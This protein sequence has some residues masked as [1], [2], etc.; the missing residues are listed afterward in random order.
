MEQD[1]THALW[2]GTQDGL[3]KFNGKDFE[4]FVAGET[5]GLESS[6][7]LSSAAAKNG[8]LWFGTTNGLSV[9]N[10]FKEK[11]ETFTISTGIPMHV[12]DIFIADDQKIWIASSTH[13]IQ[14]FNPKVKKFTGIKKRNELQRSN[15]IC[16]LANDHVLVGTQDN[17]MFRW[18]PK[19]NGI[20]NLVKSEDRG[21]IEVNNIKK[22]GK[23]RVFVCTNK[24]LFRYLAPSG[25]LIQPFEILQ[26]NYGVLNVTDVISE[27][28]TWYISTANRG[29]FTIR[30]DGSVFNSSQDVFQKYALLFNEINIIYRDIFGTFWLGTQRGISNFDPKNQGFYGVGPVAD[31]TQGLPNASVWSFAEDPT[32]QFLYVGTD[33]AV[34]QYDRSGGKFRHFYRD[35][36]ALN[37]TQRKET[38]VLSIFVISNDRLLVAC[39]DGLYELSILKNSYSFKPLIAHWVQDPL[40]NKAYSICYYKEQKFFIGTRGGVI[41]YDLQKNTT[42]IFKHNANDRRNSIVAGACRL[43]YKDKNGKIWFATSGGGLNYL[44]E[45]EGELLIVPYER[46]DILAKFSK[47]Y[48]TSILH[49]SSDEYWLG[50]VGSGVLKHNVET[51]KTT[52]YDKTDGLPNNFIY[53]LLMDREGQ[54]WMSTNRGLCRFSP[55]SGAVRNYSEVDGLMSNEMNL[56]AYM[57]ALD[58]KLYFGGISGF[59]YFDPRTLSYNRPEVEVVFTKFKLDDQWLKPGE[60]HGLFGSTFA[61]VDKITLNHHQR[62]FT[63][64][65]QSSDLSNPELISYRY[66]LIGS[67]E[68]MINLGNSNELRFN[69]LPYGEYTLRVYGKKGVGE[70]SANPAIL[71]I[72]LIPPFWFRW[73]FFVLL[74]VFLALAIVYYIRHKLDAER[75]EQVR[76]EM[77]IQE[78]TREIR[79]QSKK[80]ERQR[81]QIEEERNKVIEQQ[82]LLQAEKEKSD[83]LLNNI[84]PI[85]TAEELKRKGR[86]NARAYRKV[87]VLFTDFVGFTKI[88]DVLRPSELVQRLDF[89]FT[90]F[91]E[92][93]EQNNLEK[94]K[95]IGDAYMAAGGVPVRNNTNPVEACLAGLQIQKFIEQVRIES[96]AKGEPSWNLRLGINTGEVTAGVIGSK[97]FAYDVWGATVNQAQRMEMMGEPGKVTITGST[98]KHVMPFFETT[99]KGKVKSKSRGM[100]E[101]FTVDRIKPELSADGLG[102][103]PNDSFRK[104]FDLQMY[105]AIN[106]YKAERH[107]IKVLEKGLNDH[108]YYHCIDHT[109]D[110]V[111]AAESLA[112]QEGVTD[113]GLYLLKS[114]ATYHDAGFV[115]KY[116]DNEPI[117]ARMAEEILPNY[118]YT[119]DQIEQVKRLIYVTKI[120]HQPQSHL[121]EIICDAD[122][123][124]LGRD[125]FHEISDRLRR[126]LKEH[127][128]ISGDRQWDEIQIDFLS[129]HQYF[130]KTANKMRQQKKLRNLEEVKIRYEKGEYAD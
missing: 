45:K 66:E 127:G 95:T 23:D 79:E 12:D 4:I 115:E 6:F 56:G 90:R 129:K 104:I 39:G 59:N 97:R 68:G 5:E 100:L 40:M 99:F 117:G 2:I 35:V 49:S 75:R 76:L 93:I 15:R 65:F 44:K 34:S 77:K 87:T 54:I 80:I 88:S 27:E 60:E 83:A 130:T 103:Y 114:A 48:I 51:R 18:N 20:Q 108:L 110:V 106:Y 109:K 43:V 101:M 92:I 19:T 58:G 46:N 55:V 61:L 84:M 116:D 120:P 64:Q 111:R 10:P 21:V 38:M 113:E 125:D 62:S 126:E 7:I 1:F 26:K 24:G 85:D 96:E 17:G 8:F 91:D 11:F 52:L 36:K 14:L 3:N 9:Y 119:D 22:L 16:V 42:Q 122:L 94:I 57:R 81:K 112:I 70:W 31:L 98:Y 69:F 53:G 78:R 32:G 124:Y 50:T 102:I 67:D 105:S 107:I 86:A 28:G 13:G 82:G 74:A 63:I 37:E 30:N 71:K 25:K 29:L 72:E 47:D 118:G 33:G 121:E 41:L 89:F 128:K 73:W 123:D